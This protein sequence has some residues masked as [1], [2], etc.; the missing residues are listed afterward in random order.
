MAISEQLKKLVDQMPAADRRGMYT[1]DIDKE[2]IEKNAASIASGGK[3][4]MLGLIEMLGEPGST[5]NVKPH[6]ALHCALNHAL[7]AKDEKLR[8]ELCEAI[9]SQLSND[10]LLPDTRAYLCQELQWAGRDEACAALGA[11]LLDEQISDDAATALAAIGGER[12]AEQ[13]RTAAGKAKGKSRLNLIDA[14]AALPEAKSAE[15]FRAAL[16]DSDREVRIAAALGLA[17][18]G[19]ADS[20]ESLL[21]MADAAQGWERTQLTKATLVLAEQL[22]ATGNKAAATRIYQRLEKT[23]TGETEQHIRD[24]AKLGLAAV[25]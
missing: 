19:Q 20:A 5:E 13:L 9:A 24:A 4:N 15:T 23:R 21:K 1:E 2:K 10:Q 6:Y 17:Q 7:V 11:V 18:L 8:K 16:D 14:L 3:A 22:A 12:A 25:G